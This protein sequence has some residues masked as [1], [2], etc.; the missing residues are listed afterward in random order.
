MKKIPTLIYYYLR[1]RRINHALKKT[2]TFPKVYARIPV[3]DIEKTNNKIIQWIN[4]DRP[5]AIGRFGASEMFCASSFEFSI[6]RLR[7]KSMEQLCRWSGFFP[8]DVV[9]G[10]DFN[11]YM[12]NAMKDVDML[13]VWNLRFEEYYIRKYMRKDICLTYL[14]NLEP[15]KAPEKPWTSA[16]ENKKVLVIH[17]F[18]NTI[19][20]QYKH[21]ADIFPGTNILPEF[22]LKT[23]K[24]VQTIA[25]EKDER[26]SNWFDA[27]DWMYREA[28]KIDFD[29]A[30]LGCGAYGLPLT[31]MLKA[32]GKKAIH[33]GG[34]TQILFGIKGKRWDHEA[35]YDYVR[36][37][38]NENWVYPKQEDEV[39]NKKIVENGCYWS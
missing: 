2:I 10:N 16:L 28:M 37:F 34:A 18:E 19:Q 1:N 23:L 9:H 27:L 7:E 14:L 4:E 30:I 33:L 13:A 3:F 12:I 6:K 26:F 15:W 8:N 32:S 22:S 20:A 35:A 17:P 31:S 5:I 38:Y 21:R 11:Y 29:V 24:A 39:K 36:N 25:G